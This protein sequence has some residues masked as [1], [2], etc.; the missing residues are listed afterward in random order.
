L[1]AQ[2]RS[3]DVADLALAEHG[4]ARVEWAQRAM[5]V[6]AHI[7]E[8]FAR[9]RPLHG[10][11]V[12]ACMHVTA[13]TA[14]LMRTL[15]A[16]G[17]EVALAAANPLATQ[18][19]VAAGLVAAYDISVFA[20]HG[21]DGETYLRHLDAVLEPRPGY[22]L[23]DACDLVAR[24]HTDRP[25]LADG[26]RAGCE[27]TTTGVI[28]LRRMAAAGALRFP[29]LAV[30][31][32]PAMRMLDNRYGTGQSTIDAVLRATNMLLAGR[33]VVVSG[34]GYCGRGI[35]ERARGLGALVIV[36]E[37]DPATA[38]D[39]S[40]AGFRVLPMAE[41]APLGDV[42]LTATGGRDVLRAEHFAVMKDGAVLGNAGHFDVEIDLAALERAATARRRVR[43]HVDEFVLPGGR[44]L[45]LLAQG[46][47][48][49]LAAGEGHP[50][51]VMDVAFASQALGLA[52]LVREAGELAPLVYGVPAHI[53][54][55]VARLELDALGI[56][57]DTL[58]SEQ[59]AYLSSWEQRP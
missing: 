9:Q 17:A 35:A 46:R 34:Y 19:D 41:A 58:T 8:R 42:F 13:E 59:E 47:V 11:R 6:L 37:V 40:M 56:T 31:D 30:N 54:A 18:D 4:R 44:R 1:T 16:G 25:E 22:L 23:D 27:E 26:V 32:T 29:M 57:I 5:P 36:T 51:A 43:A 33:T 3:H 24:L 21:A 14:N 12:A 10:I 50:A 52:W 28:R 48:V 39:A 55:E 20:R 49:N 53:D 15:Q 2:R 38:L 7:R 45:L